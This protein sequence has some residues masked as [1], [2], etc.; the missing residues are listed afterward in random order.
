M[1]SIGHHAI[2]F[3]VALA[4]S[5]I[6][7]IAGIGGGVII[8]P[9]MDAF[10]VLG[11]STISFLSGLTVLSMSGYNVLRSLRSPGGQLKLGIAVPLGIGA[12]L[13]GV[14]GKMLFQQVQ[15]ATGDPRMTGAI[16]SGCLILV[17]LLTLLYTLLSSRIRTRNLTSRALIF[18]SGCA[19]GILSSFLGIGGG[20]INLMVLCYCFSMDIKEAAQNSLMVILLSQV[21]SLLT[22]LL[23]HSVPPFSP[24]LLCLLVAGG[25]LGGAA[26]RS[27]NRRL[28]V[29]QVDTLYRWTLVG[30]IGITTYNLL[31]FLG[32]AG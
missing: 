15:A 5:A 2:F 10:R 29:R 22:T 19:L 30:I 18:L 25:I 11:V 7:S 20:P 4:A 9:A 17:T 26:G 23:T 3:L 32:P 14:V 24:A 27:W 21:T 31:N 6:G 13:G 1:V 12:S 8:K 28:S 16:Q